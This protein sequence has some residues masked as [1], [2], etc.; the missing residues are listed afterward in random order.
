MRM[1]VGNIAME[2]EET[3]V[4]ERCRGVIGSGG[5]VGS[6]EALLYGMK[7]LLHLGLFR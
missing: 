4:Q 7:R 5:F 2:L 6:V 3:L 1:I